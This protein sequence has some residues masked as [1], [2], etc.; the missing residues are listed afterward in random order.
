MRPPQSHGATAAGGSGYELVLTCSRF[1][2]IACVVSTTSIHGSR[3]RCHVFNAAAY[4]RRTPSGSFLVRRRPSPV[5]FFRGSEKTVEKRRGTISLLCARKR[6]S[7]CRDGRGCCKRWQV[8]FFYCLSRFSHFRSLLWGVERFGAIF[9]RS[10]IVSQGL[11]MW[12]ST[13][14]VGGFGRCHVGRV[15]LG[16]KA[17]QYFW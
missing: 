1:R 14:S 3:S 2:C 11:R 4:N 16:I 13:M 6:D 12:R 7:V 5:A 10:M 15:E 9:P 8:D 17:G